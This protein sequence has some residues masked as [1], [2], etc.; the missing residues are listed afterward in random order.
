MNNF[1]RLK[2]NC[3]EMNFQPFAITFLCLTLLHILYGLFVFEF[4]IIPRII[5]DEYFE[6][7]YMIIEDPSGKRK[8]YR[9]EVYLCFCGL[10]FDTQYF[11]Y[12]C[13]NFCKTKRF[14]N[15]GWLLKA[16]KYSI[17]CRKKESSCKYIWWFNFY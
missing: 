15:Y 13:S 6:S 8:S 7:W 2:T 4:K 5:Q 16:S 12:F 14:K 10:L 9:F 3:L 17:T 1:S 11:V